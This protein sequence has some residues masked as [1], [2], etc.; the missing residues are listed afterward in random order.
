MGAAGQRTSPSMEERIG[1]QTQEGKA[2][3]EEE[4]KEGVEE[5][6]KAAEEDEHAKHRG[7]YKFNA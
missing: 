6:E 1:G 2:E 5:E 3:E 4:R 7:T